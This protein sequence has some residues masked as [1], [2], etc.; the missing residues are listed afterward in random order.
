MQFYS[1]SKAFICQVPTK[2]VRLLLNNYRP[3]DLVRMKM[4]HFHSHPFRCVLIR[5]VLMLVK[6]DVQSVA[7]TNMKYG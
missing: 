6:F 5:T 1:I 3:D 2:Y 4:K 7:S